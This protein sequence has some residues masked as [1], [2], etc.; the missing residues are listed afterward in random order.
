MDT[1]PFQ[2]ERTVLLNTLKEN[3]IERPSLP[4]SPLPMSPMQPPTPTPSP[5][6]KKVI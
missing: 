4:A 1:I 6:E 3:K 2:A 5:S